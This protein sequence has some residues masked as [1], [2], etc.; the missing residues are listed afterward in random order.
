MQTDSGPQVQLGGICEFGASQG[1]PITEDGGV[2]AFDL[3]GA[4]GKRFGIGLK[5][6]I[7]DGALGQHLISLIMQAEDAPQLTNLID[8]DPTIRDVFGQPVP[9][10]TYSPHAFEKQAR[11][12]YIP[13][14][15]SVVMN[16]GATQTFVA[17]CD[18]TLGGPPTSRHIMGTL[19]MGNDPAT[20]VVD[21]N[22]RF[23]DVD[24]L[25]ACDGGVF[26]TSS[27]YNPTLTIFAVAAKIAH[28]IAGTSP[29]VD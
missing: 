15:R 11:L 20:S 2:Y 16:A 22:G 6:A 9:R 10:I 3:P 21:A 8:L 7:R 4:L 1:R 28:G 23:H 17:P 27:G 24:N 29:V 14:M 5:N 12:F 25:Y 19:R 26:T 13:F 18:T